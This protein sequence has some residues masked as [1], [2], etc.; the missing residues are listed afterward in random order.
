MTEKTNV[1]FPEMSDLKKFLL[2]RHRGVVLFLLAGVLIAGTLYFLWCFLE[3]RAV[4]TI[5][6]GALPKASESFVSGNQVKQY[7]GKHVDFSYPAVYLEKHHE[8]PKNGPV[9]E[10]IFLSATNFEG[11]KISLMVEDRGG[12]DFEA[13]PSFQMRLNEAKEYEKEAF[14][15]N[16]FDGF[17]F[18]K[19]TQVFEQ[20]AFFFGEG[21]FISVVLS[22]PTTMDSLKDDLMSVV[23]SMKVKEK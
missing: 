21:L 19:K 13:S 22:S 16:G 2:K 20:D 7:V 4:G 18:A 5:H 10:S 23:K 3:K 15:E 11:R 14:S 8:T 17:L 1:N 12:T 6:P 9:K